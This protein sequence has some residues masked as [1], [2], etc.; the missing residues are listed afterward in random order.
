MTYNVGTVGL[1]HWARRFRECVHNSPIRITKAVGTRAFEEK[2]HELETYSINK[3]RYFRIGAG[4]PIP[5]EFFDGLVAVHIVSP[6][7]FHMNQAK[8]SLENDKVT[9]VE[10]TFA[11]TKNDFA[12]FDMKL[13]QAVVFLIQ[14]GG[15]Q[16]T[17]GENSDLCLRHRQVKLSAYRENS[18]V[19]CTSLPWTMKRD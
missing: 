18:E 6:N 4:D 11:V 15:R 14:G 16:N 1:G 19:W 7:Q 12:D 9:V 2:R 8:N 13:G 10:K 3:D 5:K 17:K